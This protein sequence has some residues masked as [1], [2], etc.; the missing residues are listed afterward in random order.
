MLRK[1][2]TRA[3]R[4]NTGGAYPT[5]NTGQAFGNDVFS[6][7]LFVVGDFLVIDPKSKPRFDEGMTLKEDYDFTSQHL[8]KY[9]VVARSNRLIVIAKHYTNAGGAVEARND[10]REQY[11]IAVLRHKWPGV[12]PQHATRGVN[13]VRMS[14]KTRDIGLGGKRAITRPPAPKGYVA[15]KIGVP[16]VEKKKSIMSFFG[17]N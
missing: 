10:E 6:T 2:V 5:Q 4:S 9:G 7:D 3:S 11:N 17:K 15:S 8:K 14:W 12:F 13:E 16:P 1:Y